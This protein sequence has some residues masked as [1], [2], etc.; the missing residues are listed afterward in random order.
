MRQDEFLSVHPD[1]FWARGLQLLTLEFRFE[2][3]FSIRSA[4]P[5]G[6][7]HLS[8][9]VLFGSNCMQMPQQ[10][11]GVT[12]ENA[13][14]VMMQALRYREV[15]VQFSLPGVLFFCRFR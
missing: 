10:E 11:W 2:M 8:I 4:E 15:L 14:M 6:K 9:A 12:E 5:H 3:Q 1:V 13:M 7:W